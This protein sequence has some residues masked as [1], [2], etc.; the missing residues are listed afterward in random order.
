VSETTSTTQST[1]AAAD[2]PQPAPRLTSE[3]FVEQL[4]ALMAQVPD[5]PSLTREERRLLQRHQRVPN[6]EAQAAINVARA[7]DKLA[8]AVSDG[9]SDIQ[10]VLENSYR[11]L[12]A[13]NELKA[14]LKSVADA[15]LVRKQRV[16]AFAVET[17]GV[18][19]QLARRPE[20]SALVPH[21]AEIKRMRANRRRKKAEPAPPAPVTASTPQS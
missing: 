6:E 14:A 7:S 10:Q 15:N 3:Q 2:T 20:N 5:V 21:V 1:P 18:G 8:G 16:A 12:A 4:R 19:Q 17:Y 9:T 13:E 11:W